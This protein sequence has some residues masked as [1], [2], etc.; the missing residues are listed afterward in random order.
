MLPPICYI[1]IVV[2][3]NFGFQCRYEGLRALH[4]DLVFLIACASRVFLHLFT[5]NPIAG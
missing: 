3:V 2:D 4:V 1:R 5:F